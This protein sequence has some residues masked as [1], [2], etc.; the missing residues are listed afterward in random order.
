MC[1]RNQ[2]LT[3]NNKRQAKEKKKEKKRKKKSGE[4]RNRRQYKFVGGNRS[5]ELGWQEE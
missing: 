1:N 3:Y 5:R 2:L 4:T